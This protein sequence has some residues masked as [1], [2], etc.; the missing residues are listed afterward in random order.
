MRPS[1]GLM[2]AKLEV[3]KKKIC[4]VR[5][6]TSM[7]SFRKAIRGF[8][9]PSAIASRKR[10]EGE[11]REY[12]LDEEVDDPEDPPRLNTFLARAVAKAT[13]EE[14]GDRGDVGQPYS[15]Q[16][17]A[18]PEAEV[19]LLG[20]IELE[21]VERTIDVDGRPPP[22]TIFEGSTLIIQ[23]ERVREEEMVTLV[24]EE[25][26]VTVVKEEEVYNKR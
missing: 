6:V 23:K 18:D 24:R 19:D 9:E 1:I 25:E 20:D 10:V 26:M 3:A 5:S 21:R 13:T 14:E 11:R 2:Y 7:K 16:F 15:P 4:E 17:Q 8:A 22:H 12:E